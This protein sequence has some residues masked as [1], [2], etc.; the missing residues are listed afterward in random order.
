V[1]IAILGY[2][3]EGRAAEAWLRRH[4]P[5]AELTVIERYDGEDLGGVDLAV[6]SPS[7]PPRKIV[8]AKRVTTGTQI[9]FQHCPAVIVGVTGTKGKGTTASLLTA[10]LRRAG[11]TVHLVGNIGQPALSVLDEVAAEDVVV[12]ELSSFQL[13][14][15]AVSPHVAVLTP[16][17]AD[18]LDVHVDMADYLAAKANIVK[19]QTV[20]DVVIYDATNERA[21]VIAAQSAGRQVAY[22]TENFE[23]ELPVPGAHNR[24]NA[25]AA[26]L[27]AAEL[28]VTDMATIQAGLLDFTGLPHRLEQV[29]ELDGVRYVDDSFA[30]ASPALKVAVAAYEAPVILIAGGFDRGLQ[31]AAEIATYLNGAANV[32]QV[33]LIGQTAP[34]L[35]VGLTKPHEIMPTLDM[36]VGRAHELAT[37]GDVVLLS[38]GAPSFD[39]FKNFAERGEKFKEAVDEL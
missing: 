2:G 14:D 26:V 9:F 8:G 32:K 27:V 25:E 6:R 35:A 13:W 31:N 38:P 23:Y 18:H 37:V 10:I 34:A 7:L 19:Y 16:I 36:A 11:R 21:A 12:Y 39:M 5:A 3:A 33:L 24:R 29:R 20:N 30:A 22:P 28:G 1:K 17:E 15:L 4:E